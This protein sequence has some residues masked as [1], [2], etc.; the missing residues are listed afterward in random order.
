MKLRQWEEADFESFAEM[1]SDPEVTRYVLPMTRSESLDAF[2][3]IRKEITQRGRG[4]W[5]VEADG[6][7]AGMVG[8]QV[9][10]CPLPFAPCTE[11]L[12]RLRREFWGLGIAYEAASEAIN[13][14]FSKAE[15]EE[16]VTFTTPLNLRSIRL[17]ERL[18]FERDHQGDFDHP[19]I[20]EG[21]DYRRHVLYR[22]K[23]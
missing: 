14:G 9:P 19:E 7:L 8:L 20:P 6:T 5:A 21:S 1:N 22:K 16:I 18:G 23:S 3:R 12:W 10:E 4:I 11:I 13:Y 17:M 15:L 2:S